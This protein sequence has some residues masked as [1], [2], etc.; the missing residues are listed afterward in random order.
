M[1]KVEINQTTF[2]VIGQKD[3]E[4][5]IIIRRAKEI[6]EED[7]TKKVLWFHLD[8]HPSSHVI[9]VCEEDPTP[10]QIEMA[11]AACKA[12]SKQKKA[13]NVSVVYGPIEAVWKN[14]KGKVGSVLTNDKMM[15]RMKV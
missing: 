8:D 9:L 14:E 10:E 2:F 15:K 11:A 13:L 7:K 4:N 5:W 1:K 12:H 3:S 6:K